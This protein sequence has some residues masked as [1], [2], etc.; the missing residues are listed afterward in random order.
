MKTLLI[1]MIGCVMASGA[2]V[3]NFN[4]GLWTTVIQQEDNTYLF[5]YN[6][7]LNK[8]FTFPNIGYVYDYRI[9]F[10]KETF[11]YGTSLLPP[12]CGEVEFNGKTIT[13]YVPQVPE[14]GV[15]WLSI[16]GVFLLLRP[17]RI[18]H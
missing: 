6:Y 11:E 12:V 18:T 14:P 5:R 2:T 7:H 1:M 10:D 9:E 16:F 13:T 3:S 15:I 8:E 4:K 17:R